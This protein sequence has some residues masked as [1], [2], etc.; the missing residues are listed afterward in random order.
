[1]AE[2]QD[3]FPL[4][5]TA[6]GP[7]ALGWRAFIEAMEEAGTGTTWARD[8]PAAFTSVG[9]VDISAEISVQAFPGGSPAA[10]FWD[11]TWQQVRHRGPRS[12]T[13]EGDIDE[14]LAELRDPARWFVGPT[15]VTASGRRPTE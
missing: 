6:R 1:M 7:Y 4:D 12:G 10:R 5:A 13:R 2:E 14:T 8:L 15:M 9:I 3:R 11:L